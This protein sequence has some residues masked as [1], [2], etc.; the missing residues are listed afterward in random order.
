[1]EQNILFHPSLW[2]SNNTFIDFLLFVRQHSS[3]LGEN[4]T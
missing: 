4:Q 3:F 1:M 2:P